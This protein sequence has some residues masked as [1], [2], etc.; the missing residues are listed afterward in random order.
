MRVQVNLATRPFVEL[1]PFFLRLRLLMGLLALAGVLIALGAHFLSAKAARGQ[2][3][4]DE[5][6]DETI[7]AQRTKLRTEARMRE[8]ANAGVLDRAHFLNAL[9]LRK[10]FSWTAV[11]MDL[12][13]VLPAGLQVTSIEPGVAADGD[14]TIRLRVAGD[15]DRAV[16]LVRNLERSRRFLQPRL[17]SESSQTRE[18]TGVA[19]GRAP[20][21]L[22]GAAT[23]PTGVEFEILASYNPLPANESYPTGHT[24]AS[25]GGASA[26]AIHVS[27]AE[28]GVLSAAPSQHRTAPSLSPATN[29]RRGYPRNGV[30][31]PPYQGPGTNGA[32][33]SRTPAAGGP[34]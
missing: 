29:Q 34:R 5:L 26:K 3:Q 31:L 30:V 10:S 25:M 15:R 6:R 1:R 33:A 9:F 19:G 22:P 32:A 2:A 8:P 17:G 12:E 21:P 28:A 16:Q 13:N 18:Q 14:V 24:A 20:L 27:D 11:M 23:L 7:A 4:L